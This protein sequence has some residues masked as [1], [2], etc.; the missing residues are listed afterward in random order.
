MGMSGINVAYT[1]D[2]RC[3]RNT[4]MSLRVGPRPTWQSIIHW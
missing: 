3:L 4:R 1:F 2:K